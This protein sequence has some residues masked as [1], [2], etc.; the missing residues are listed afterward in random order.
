M[1]VGTLLAVGSA[2]SSFFGARRARRRA[3]REARRAAGRQMVAEANRQEIPSFQSDMANPYANLQVATQGAEMQAEQADIAL[4]SSLDTLRATGAGA[5]GA[6]AL[7]RA[8]AQ[9]K[10]GVSASIEK[11]EAR[12]AQ[13]RAQGEMQ[14]AQMRQTGQIAQFRAQEARDDMEIQR[15]AGLG[16]AAQQ[17]ESAARA[18]QTQAIGAAVG[19]IGTFADEGGFKNLF[20]GSS[21]SSS[22]T[23]TPV[24]PAT[25]QQTDVFMQ[26]ATNLNQNFNNQ[27]TGAFTDALSAYALTDQQRKDLAAAG[28]FLMR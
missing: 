5:G 12:N 8:A 2:I 27:T 19:A 7:A 10:R 1:S 9:S 3:R 22:T 23:P 17:Q 15:Q 25:P 11:Q 18:A 6:T 16:F 26:A 4:A 24:Q 14:A 20:G 28:G 13:L 21:S